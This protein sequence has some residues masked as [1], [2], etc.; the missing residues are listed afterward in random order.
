M[1]IV[2]IL[3]TKRLFQAISGEACYH[4]TRG[5]TFRSVINRTCKSNFWLHVLYVIACVWSRYMPIMKHTCYYKT[6]GC[7]WSLNESN[8]HKYFDFE[9][10]CFYIEI[11]IVF[12]SVLFASISKVYLHIQGTQISHNW[13]RPA[14]PR[15]LFFK[16]TCLK[17]KWRNS[18]HY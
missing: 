12:F 13:R 8:V 14:K 11:E 4:R 3:A 18:L 1:K 10:Y 7:R 6:D 5:N 17:T 9:S 2:S 16:K 15:Q